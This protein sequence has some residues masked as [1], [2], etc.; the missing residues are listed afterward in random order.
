MVHSD[1]MHHMIFS[2]SCFGK[3]MWFKQTGGKKRAGIH[4]KHKLLVVLSWKG[5]GYEGNLFK[6]GVS[7]AGESWTICFEGRP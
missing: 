2:L 6:H 1:V 5:G 3:I 7:G 4:I